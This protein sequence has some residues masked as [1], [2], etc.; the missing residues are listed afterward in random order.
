V[1]IALGFAWDIKL[2]AEHLAVG[3]PNRQIPVNW[4]DIKAS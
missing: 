3:R 1:W 4:M 2:L